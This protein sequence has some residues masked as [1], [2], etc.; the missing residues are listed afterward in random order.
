MT[1]PDDRPNPWSRE[2]VWQNEPAPPVYPPVPETSNTPSEGNPPPFY[3]AA[4][5]PPPAAPPP[6]YPQQPY[7]PAPP[8]PP[9]KGRVGLWVALGLAVAVLVGAAMWAVIADNDAHPVESSGSSGRGSVP[10]SETKV[11]TAKDQKSQLTVPAAWKDVPESFKNELATLQVGDLPQSQFVL[12]VTASTTDF[13]DFEAFA[14]AVVEEART[15]VTESDVGAARKLT[16]GGLNAQQH[17]VNGKVNGV[18][19]TYWFTVVEGKRG[20]YEVVG[21]TLP[22]RKSD[23]EPVILGV[24]DSFRE[25]GG[26]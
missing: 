23:S 15:L 19:L 4:P 18:K 26:G 12:V 14:D 8:P 1:Q 9:R 3:P 10:S 6:F 22:S 2:G 17:E 16:I 20:Y 25:L 24:I 7:P 11:V 21:W 13:D 5:T